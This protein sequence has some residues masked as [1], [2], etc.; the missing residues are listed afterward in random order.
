MNEAFSRVKHL[1]I[2]EPVMQYKEAARAIIKNFTGLTDSLSLSFEIS[3][4]I[5]VNHVSEVL[6]SHLFFAL[7][8]VATKQHNIGVLYYSPPTSSSVDDNRQ[9]PSEYLAVVRAGLVK[10]E[11]CE[12][13]RRLEEA[14]R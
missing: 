1:E 9:T 7:I 8:V 13:A 6:K 3:E 12:A 2:D 4:K 14:L 11:C 10:A 5:A